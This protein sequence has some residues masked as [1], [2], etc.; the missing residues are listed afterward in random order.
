[1]DHA[2]IQFPGQRPKPRLGCLGSLVVSILVG[3]VVFILLPAI[4]APWSFYLGG[5]FHVLPIWQGWGRL[6]SK[7]AGDFALYVYMYPSPG[8]GLGY[9]SVKGTATLCTPRGQRFNMHLGGG[10]NNK[11][12]GLNTNGQPMHLYMNTWQGWSAQ[13]TADHRPRLDL[14]GTWQNPNLVMDDHGSLSRAFLAD[15]SL[16]TGPEHNQPSAR[17]DVQITISPGGKSEFEAA[18]AAIKR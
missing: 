2:K 15:G 12:P 18:C 1:M 8:R 11:H 9:P 6:H 4:F 13:F 16:Y 10:I 5:S 7:T 17:E 3:A 14:R